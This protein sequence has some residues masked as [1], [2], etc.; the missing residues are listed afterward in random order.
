MNKTSNCICVQ[1]QIKLG[2]SQLVGA[3]IPILNLSLH[4]C[5]CSEK[6]GRERQFAS[7]VSHKVSMLSGGQE[8]RNDIFKT[9][10]F[11]SRH[12][13]SEMIWGRLENQHVSRAVLEAVGDYQKNP[14][15]F[16]LPAKNSLP[17]M[18]P[19]LSPWEIGSNNQGK[20][21]SFPGLTTQKQ[22]R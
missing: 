20:L 21:G 14:E 6:A 12:L 10:N 19:P 5:C 3:R 18:N 9:G 8:G 22:K 7:M 15:C 11:T 4:L 16:Y 1:M 2:I 13:R 17:R